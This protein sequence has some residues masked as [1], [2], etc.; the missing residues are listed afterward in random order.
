[1]SLSDGFPENVY[2]V[3]EKVNTL[4]FFSGQKVVGFLDTRIFY[5]KKNAA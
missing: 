2:P 4:S 1:M 3:I 5:A